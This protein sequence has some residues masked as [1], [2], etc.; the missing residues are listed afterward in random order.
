MFSSRVAFFAKKAVEAAAVVKKSSKKTTLE[1]AIDPPNLKEKKVS[2]S[3]APVAHAL[4]K[5][6]PP[7]AK[8]IGNTD[9]IRPDALK[10]VWEYIKTNNLQVKTCKFVNSGVHIGFTLL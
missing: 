1:A 5:V 6:A 3:R 7:L 2:T 8:L 4:M 10:K 9:V